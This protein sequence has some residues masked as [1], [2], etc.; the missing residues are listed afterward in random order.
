MMINKYKQIQKFSLIR[1]DKIETFSNYAKQIIQDNFSVPN[2]KVEIIQPGVDHQ[3]FCP[4]TNDERKKVKTSLGFNINTNIL[5]IAARLERRKGVDSAILALKQVLQKYPHTLLLI[6]FPAKNVS[7]NDSLPY[8]LELVSNHQLGGKVVFV[9]GISH[10]YLPPYY[11]MADCFLM[12]SSNLE[13]FGITTIEALACGTPVLGTPGPATK[14]ILEKIDKRLVFKGYSPYQI[15]QGINWYLSLSSQEKTHLS[16]VSASYAQE[17]YSWDK[18]VTR[19]EEIYQSLHL[20]SE[21]D[22]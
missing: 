15:A 1:A 16:Q 3:L 5:L 10:H 22:N 8:H 17:N 20:Q 9:T 14:E 2:H 6:I 11:Q 18:S 7:G 4:L 13:T 19:L 21:N 12:A